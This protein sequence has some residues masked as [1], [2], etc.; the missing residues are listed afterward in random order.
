MPPLPQ[1][2]SR[3]SA[4]GAGTAIRA[5]ARSRP[6]EQLS[7]QFARL[8]RLALR[9]PEPGGAHCSTE[10]QR[11]C[12]T[13]HFKRTVEKLPPRRPEGSTSS[14]GGYERYLEELSQKIPGMAEHFERDKPGMHTSDTLDYGIVIRGEMIPELDDVKAV[15]LRQGDCVVQNGTRHRWRNPLSEPC[16]MAFVLI[17]GVR[18]V[19]TALA[20]TCLPDD[21]G[22][23][24]VTPCSAKVYNGS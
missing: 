18:G 2:G 17:G 12:L 3:S 19:Q 22:E 23:R 8:L 1:S 21:R 20:A 7:E 4:V 9:P 11:L 14:P 16:L 6:A 24:V 5:R 13:C 15:H 10:F